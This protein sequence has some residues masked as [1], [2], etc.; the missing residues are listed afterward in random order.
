MMSM[1]TTKKLPYSVNQLTRKQENIWRMIASRSGV[2]MLK[3]K[4]GVAKSATCKAIADNVI[5]E[6]GESLQFIDLR[7]SQ[8]DET[9]FG[10]PYRKTEELNDK[11]LEVMDYALPDW[12]H[13]ASERPTLINFEEINRCSQDVQNAALEIL[14]E[15]TLHGQK[16]PDHVYM[17]ATGNM[18]EEDGCAVQEFDNAL[19]N[20]L[21]LLDFDMTFA[22][23]KEGFAN[24]NVHEYILRFLEENTEHY[25]SSN[26]NIEMGKSF[27]TPRSWDNLSAQ[28]AKKYEQ[29]GIEAV[30]AF[31]ERYA[32]SY[33]GSS[34]TIAFT[35]WLNEEVTLSL[36]DVLK[37]SEKV[38]KL[39][40]SEQQKIIED[41][42]REYITVEELSDKEIQNVV[43]F[44]SFVDEDSKA[45]FVSE[46][47]QSDFDTTEK[48]E[49]D[50]KWVKTYAFLKETVFKKCIEAL[51]AGYV[52]KDQ[53]E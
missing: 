1:F 11:E 19:I 34:A 10:F 28:V 35:T 49:P 12:F 47:F 25:Y 43:K 39:S 20:R 16:L 27:A 46:V 41:I 38:S 52:P 21:I 14:N 17:I 31:V 51:K 15:R 29:G 13:K 30:I 8:M 5:C 40:R 24:E 45:S 48:E 22:E 2:V 26:K 6:N 3:G 36:N 42:K 7:L 32:N 23:W 53:Q 37:G 4:A 18:G 33:I 9:H 44:F 50:F